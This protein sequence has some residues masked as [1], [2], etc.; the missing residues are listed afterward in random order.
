MRHTQPQFPSLYTGSKSRHGCRGWGVS[1]GGDPFSMMTAEV[2]RFF[3]SPV[4]AVVGCG[5]GGGGDSGVGGNSAI[6]FTPALGRCLCCHPDK[7]FGKGT[8][9]LHDY[10]CMTE[11]VASRVLG[12][13]LLFY[14]R[15]FW[16]FSNIL[17]QCAFVKSAEPHIC[18]TNFQYIMF[19]FV[20]NT[21]LSNIF[22][23]LM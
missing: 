17:L 11:K 13:W 20:S 19:S 9:R 12:C 21:V 23:M 2:S 4:A 1:C 3:L 15:W 18:T 22:Y 8:I 16:G 10:Y 5:G 6:I 7:G 14:F